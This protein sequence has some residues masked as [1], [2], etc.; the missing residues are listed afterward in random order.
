MRQHKILFISLLLFNLIL[1]N[2]IYAQISSKEVDK[3]VEKSM[4]KFNVA[5]AAVGIVKDGKIV[6]VKGYGVKSVKTK[7]PVN[8]HTGFAIASNTKAFTT[9]ALAILEE[10]GKLSWQD[11][12]VDII[13]E[14]KMYDPWVTAHFNILDLL[15]HRSG[16]GLGAGDLMI[17]PD[18]SDFTMNDIIKVF[19]YL[20][21]VSDFRTKYDYDNLLYMVAGEVIARVAEM[22][23]EKFVQTRIIDPL[24]MDNSCSS[25]YYVDDNANIATPHYTDEGT[26]KTTTHDIFNPEKINGAAASIISNVDDLC[27]WLLVHLNHGKYGKNL[28]KQLFSL[29]NHLEMW[30]IHTVLN[31]NRNPR[32]NAHFAGYGLGWGL[33]D[34]KGCM[35]VSHT[36]AL[37]GMLSK[38]IMIPDLDL[39]VVVLTNTWIGGAMLFNAVSKTI[40][41]HYLDLDDFDWIDFYHQRAQRSQGRADS[42]VTAVWETVNATKDSKIDLDMFIGTYQDAWF[43][44]VV[45]SMKEGRLWFT[46]LRSPRLNGP[47]YFYKANTF[48]IKW[49]S[50]ELDADAFAMFNLDEEGRASAIKMKGISPD[51]DF[52]FD[53][54]DLDLRR[55]EKE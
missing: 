19:Q 12:V 53:F 11:K 41:D 55:V 6:H 14:F 15:T 40:V 38:T 32:Y 50:R 27:Q 9:A 21:P 18:G 4:K 36:G 23:W 1:S 13:P 5:G 8:E 37:S 24:G 31:A 52:S 47:M 45:I 51:I 10:E 30:K 16:L 49:V 29:E 26:L 34:I 33:T 35:S 28:E 46:C 22:P 39:G 20:K 25:M 54:H 44:K 48:A 2:A 3:L 43:G 17:F 42:V 7:A